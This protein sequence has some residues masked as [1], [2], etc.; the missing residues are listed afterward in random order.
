[1]PRAQGESVDIGCHEVDERSLTLAVEVDSYAVLLGAASTF[2][3]SA[4]GGSG[5]RYKWN[6]GDGSEE[7]VTES[8]TVQ[9][10]YSAGLYGASVAVSVDGGATWSATAEP[11]GAIVVAPE[12]IYVNAANANPVFPYDTPAKE[13]KTGR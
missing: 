13:H 9:H 11:A 7:L 5:Y 12:D 1:M 8:A 3:A 4:T 2:S 10:T 6:F